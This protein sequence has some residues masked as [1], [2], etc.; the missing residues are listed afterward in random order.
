MHIAL[1]EE[2]MF[3][4][5]ESVIKDI[6]RHEF[7]HY[8]QFIEFPEAPLGHGDT[9][10]SICS[11]FKWDQGVSSPTMNITTANDNIEGE[12]QSERIIRKVKALLKLSE[13][14]NAH[15]AELATIKANELLLKHQISKLS[16][17]ED[18]PIYTHR[19][20]KSSR[21]NSKLQAIYEIL[22]HFMVNTILRYGQKNV[23]LEVSGC[24]E[25]TELADYIAGYLDDHFESLW[26]ESPLKGLKAKNSFYKGI[27]KG[28]SE[29][30]HSMQVSSFQ[31]TDLVALK[32]DLKFQHELVYKRT[33]TYRSSG[34]TSLGAFL[35]GKKKG[36]SLTINPAIKSKS[37]KLLE[38]LN[39]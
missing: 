29:K 37:K 14:S 26:K 13:S 31:K 15:E 35:S 8:I 9:F 25:N 39:G 21:N 28:Y 12:L 33:S 23:Y 27:A 3:S 7:A 5:K 10:K 24:K 4:A 11:R 1:S 6:L 32:E 38:F 17:S 22:Q 18:K 19:V 20:L 16:L 30:M 34:E 36:R 2:L